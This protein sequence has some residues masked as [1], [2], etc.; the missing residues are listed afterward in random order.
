MLWLLNALWMHCDCNCCCIAAALLLQVV[1]PKVP[2]VQPRAPSPLWQWW[3]RGKK[4]ELP[5]YIRGRCERQWA[6]SG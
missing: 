1:D 6:F 2:A 4:E 3:T 5:E